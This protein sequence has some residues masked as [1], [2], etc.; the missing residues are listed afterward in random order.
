MSGTDRKDKPVWKRIGRSLDWENLYYKAR[1]H[2]DGTFSSLILKKTNREIINTDRYR[3]NELRGR[4]PDGDW[5]TSKDRGSAEWTGGEVADILRTKGKAGEIPYSMTLFLYRQLPWID[6]ELILEFDNHSVGDFT[7]DETK[8]NLYWPFDGSP[9]IYSGIGGGITRAL[10]ERP[11]LAVDWVALE[12]PYGMLALRTEGAFKHWVRDGVLA[13]VLGWGARGNA[14]S[15]RRRLHSA[16]K[17]FD[18]RLKDSQRIRYSLRFSDKGVLRS[19]VPDWAMSQSHRPLAIPVQTG[20]RK[21]KE[22]TS[23]TFIQLPQGV[24]ATS[25]RTENKETVLRLY[26]TQKKEIPLNSETVRMT[27]WSME[28]AKDLQGNLITRMAPYQIVEIH[29]AKREQ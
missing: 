20:K 11:I 29:L 22:P 17:E 15:N 6:V 8:L 19:G 3:G 1:I 5:F 28:Y 18:F 2:P 4:T 10:P 9:D 27:D 23:K 25:L 14:Y 21:G 16:G 12:T 26:S 7:L 24:I 13:T